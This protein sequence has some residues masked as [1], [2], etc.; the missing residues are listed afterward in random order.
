MA[1]LSVVAGEDRGLYAAI[2]TLRMR[3]N[4]DKQNRQYYP[5]KTKSFKPGKT[6]NNT[7]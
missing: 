4:P 1:N 2:D 6:K 7:Y 5:R 3:M